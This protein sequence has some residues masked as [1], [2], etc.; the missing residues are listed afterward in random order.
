[1]CSQMLKACKHR[2]RVN[3]RFGFSETRYCRGSSGSRSVRRQNEIH[4]RER[5]GVAVSL[6]Q[7]A[8][9]GRAPRCRAPVLDPVRGTIIQDSIEDLANRILTR[10]DVVKVPLFCDAP[11]SGF[12]KLLVS[13]YFFSHSSIFLNFPA[14][15]GFGGAMR[16]RASLTKPEKRSA[17]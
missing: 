14:R 6:W 15:T 3:F 1:E 8:D 9:G 16:S 5:S 17:S 12:L 2:E 4:L 7:G 13:V 11:A 10:L